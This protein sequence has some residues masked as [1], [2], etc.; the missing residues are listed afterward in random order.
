MKDASS[1]VTNPEDKEGDDDHHDDEDEGEKT[2]NDSF[3][4]S[5]SQLIPSYSTSDDYYHDY[6]RPTSISQ[7][8]M[9]LSRDSEDEIRQRILKGEYVIRAPRLVKNPS[10]IGMM[11]INNSASD[12]SNHNRNQHQL[13][14]ESR[15]SPNKRKKSGFLSEERVSAAQRHLLLE[16]LSE[17][18]QAEERIIGSQS[19]NLTSRGT[20]S[21]SFEEELAYRPL[22]EV[23][24]SQRFSDEL[25]PGI[26]D[27][28]EPVISFKPGQQSLE[29]IAEEGDE[30]IPYD[31]RERGE[32]T[33]AVQSSEKTSPAGE[34]NDSYETAAL[35]ARKRKSEKNLK[36]AQLHSTMSRSFMIRH[37]PVPPTH[38][39]TLHR[40]QTSHDDEMLNLWRP[41]SQPEIST[42]SQVQLVPR[43][44]SSSAIPSATPSEDVL[45]GL[46]YHPGFQVRKV[47]LSIFSHF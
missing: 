8:R 46:P 47:S 3:K 24:V 4:P 2:D 6:T 42:R 45:F 34:A 29:D 38:H 44:H 27:S 12:D 43:Y 14:K 9:T 37:P 25:L 30:R 21:S 16:S 5:D 18:V 20:F 19:T 13:Q 15:K 39:P 40:Q 35:L 11:R 32:K 31:G 23:P 22:P 41:T 17:D 7:L 26:G 1:I 10:E 36:R 28:D 33:S